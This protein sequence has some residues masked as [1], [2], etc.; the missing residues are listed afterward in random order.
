MAI[1]TV[2]ESVDLLRSTA[3]H[4]MADGSMSFYPMHARAILDVLAAFETVCSV[5][6]ALQAQI[7]AHNPP[8]HEVI[9]DYGDDV[10]AVTL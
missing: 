1:L 2:Q 4:V 3:N 8:A 6:D 5:C 7:D 9:D 10:T